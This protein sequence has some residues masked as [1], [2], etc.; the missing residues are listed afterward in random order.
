[1]A[2]R[3]SAPAAA[4]ADS[5]KGG[6]AS[7]HSASAVT[8]VLSGAKQGVALVWAVMDG[9][10]TVDTAH[11]GR[12]EALRVT[13]GPSLVLTFI[14]WRDIRIAGEAWVLV[15]DNEADVS[16]DDGV[17]TA[18]LDEPDAPI[19][20]DDAEAIVPITDPEVVVHA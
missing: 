4:A 20:V 18:L 16:V 14:P 2:V 12:V 15:P 1:M 10:A 11:A 5:A 13:A 7:A 3:L 17:A 8:G 19:P 9:L 6:R